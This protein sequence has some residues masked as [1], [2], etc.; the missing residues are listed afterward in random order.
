MAHFFDKNIEQ[1][2]KRSALLA[3]RI[4]EMETPEQDIQVIKVIKVKDK[5]LYTALYKNVLL[6]SKYDPAKEASDKISKIDFESA[7]FIPVIG[8]GFGYHI[9]EILKRSGERCS[10]VVFITDMKLFRE[11]LMNVDLVEVLRDSRLVLLDIEFDGF[12]KALLDVIVKSSTKL[13]QLDIYEFEPEKRLYTDTFNKIRGRLIDIVKYSVKVV[14]ND[15]GDTLKGFKHILDNMPVIIN[16]PKIGLKGKVP[17]ICVAAGPSLNKNMHLLK[18][19]KGKALIICADTVAEKLVKEGIIPDVISVLEREEVVYDYF[20]KDKVYPD[21]TL[22]VGGSVIYPPIF[23][24]FKGPK[25][26]AFRK[27]TCLEKYI[28]QWVKADY[29]FDLGASVA[30]MNTGLAEELGCDPIILIGQDLS[31]GNNG[32]THADGTIYDGKKVDTSENIEE[33]LWID[34]ING[35]KVLTKPIWKYFLEWFEQK[36]ALSSRTYINATEGGANIRGTVVKTLEEAISELCREGVSLD[37]SKLLEKPDSCLKRERLSSLREGLS[38]EYNELKE[39]TGIISDTK[40]DISNFDK[41]LDKYYN[42]DD[43]EELNKHII[44]INANIEFIYK[45]YKLFN[46]LTQ[47]LYITLG[48]ENNRIGHIKDIDDCRRWIEIQRSF[49]FYLEHVLQ[50]TLD[51][52]DYGFKKIAEVEAE[53]EV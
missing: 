11:A 5:E 14:G 19:A 41:N 48:R 15:P 40:K 36:I 4:N 1:L 31:F 38:K 43:V 2:K 34:G 33:L 8:F 20:F 30:H 12:E 23:Q 37:L 28:S 22:L 53:L 47:S 35:E 16:N 44:P 52:F 51:L 45:E 50:K 49:F 21:S 17:A 39:I 32:Q 24:E 7:L 29:A 10:V 18:K 27:P 3:K 26:T 25:L 6:H 46:F 42:P 9:I 13:G